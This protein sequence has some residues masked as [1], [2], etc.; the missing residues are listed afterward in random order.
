MAN[1]FVHSLTIDAVKKSK[2]DLKTHLTKNS[3]LEKFQEIMDFGME[4]Y[5]KTL[6]NKEDHMALIMPKL[7]N[8]EMDRIAV[9]DQI[10]LRMALTE[11]T[12][13]NSIPLKVT[14]NEYLDIS[15]EYSTPKSKDFINGI[16]DKI[17]NELKENGKIQ[18][19]G[20]GLINN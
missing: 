20:R 9:L 2:E 1:L 16:L 8:W 4:L 3:A 19:M 6:S 13:F 12:E 11:F 5:F 17:M 18:K 15:K 14:I 7:K 10:I